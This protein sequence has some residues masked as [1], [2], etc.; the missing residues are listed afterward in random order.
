[1]SYL[2]HVVSS[3]GVQPN[4]DKVI[5]ILDYSAPTT[6][7]QLE[8]FIGMVAWYHKFIP[9]FADIAEPL[10]QLRRK[11]VPWSWTPTCQSAFD[12]LRFALTSDPILGFPA[13]D[14]QFSIH[15]EASN[16]GLG[17][18]LLQT[19]EGGQRTIAFGSRA[20]TS[21]ERNYSATEKEC[22]AVVWALEKWRPYMYIEGR[23][24]RVVTDH[25]ALCWLFRKSKQTGRLARWI[26]RLQDFTSRAE[27]V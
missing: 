21:A 24:C 26:L 16:V 8:H 27:T 6:L 13:P 22:L 12:T 1:M 19:Q 7:K 4:P 11:D 15:T 9:N 3:N 2:G 10:Y 14:G 17:A 18:I 25:Q 5:A 23:H 20:L